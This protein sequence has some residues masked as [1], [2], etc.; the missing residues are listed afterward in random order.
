MK[1]IISR[2][3]WFFL[4]LVATALS[5]TLLAESTSTLSE[6]EAQTLATDAYIYGYPLVTMEMTRKVMTNVAAP[7][8]TRAPM[9]QFVNMRE[10]PTA[11]FQDVTAPNADTL[12]SS[13]WLDLSKEPYILHIPNENGR[14]YLM[15]ILSGWTDVFAVPGKRTTGTEE[16]NYA[17][18]GPGWSGTL[19]EGVKE[20][21]SPTNLVWILGRTYSTGTPEDYKEVHAIQDQYSVTPLSFYGKPYTPPK[22][23]VDPNLDMKTSVRAQVGH[24]DGAHYFTMLAKLMKDNPPAKEDA[25]MVEN[26]K[27]L[28]I[29]PGQEFD[30][31][32]V[33]PKIAKALN[34][35]PK[36]A[37]SKMKANVKTVGTEENGWLFGKIVGQYGTHYLQR[38]IVAAIGLGANRLQDAIY[39]MA[40]VDGKNEPLDG[41]NNYVIHFEKGKTP[42]VKGFWSL[43]MYN[44]K[45]FFVKNPLNKYTVSER[46]HLKQ[47]A[48]GS[49]D[50]Y[51]QNESPGKDKESNWLPAPADKFT[52][53]F[54][55]YWPEESIIDG[56]WAP[57]AV[58]K[59]D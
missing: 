35:A 37:L 2:A 46:D 5:T 19:P 3:K 47:N 10:Y 33:D 48:D 16:A 30:I 9:G 55:F 43:T 39:P 12:Y 42:P 23:T 56:S 51:I 21:K 50:I 32:A 58:Q 4:P 18:T 1:N 20:F 53:M 28:G 24:L 25:P 59:V 17:I 34:N 7:E 49:I 22:G 52:L 14:Y 31:N 26:L 54:R 13:V 15:P 57:P 27:K 45:F 8:G 38:A 29:I 41:K 6:E 11:D 40:T 44:D 36:L